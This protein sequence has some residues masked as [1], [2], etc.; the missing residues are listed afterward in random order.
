MDYAREAFSSEPLAVDALFVL[1]VDAQANGQEDVMHALLEGGERLTKRNRNIGALQLQ[2]AALTGD[3]SQTFGII[4][5]LAVV[6]PD[7]TPEFVLPL[8]AALSDE[9]AVGLLR[10]A[11]ER[12]PVWQQSFWMSVPTDA[13]RVQR[14]YELRQQ[15]ENG[16]T[17]RSDARLLEALARFALYDEAFVFWEQISDSEVTPTAYVADN[18][19]PPF[20]WQL[21]S[22][23]QRAMTIRGDGGFDIYVQNETS[24]ELARQL[25][26][27]EPGRY[28]FSLRVNP[29]GEA[30]NL[31][32]QLTCATSNEQVAFGQ[33]LDS[34]AEWTVS[35]ACRH[36][37]LVLNGSSWDRRD[38][39][40]VTISDL[41][42]Q[43]G[44]RAGR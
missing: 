27:L 44:N 29:Y 43:A 15:V 25:V 35:G 37:W 28:S 32:A 39:L 36:Y 33:S 2:Q 13:G 41:R 34:V 4:D 20:G 12:E 31:A 8:V 5:R 42:F 21:T 24:G 18:S 19:F 30:D 10:D 1:A 3:L 7:L 40:R 22:I 16:T 26:R 14:M 9:R 11:L 17:P 38:P 6:Y 23:G